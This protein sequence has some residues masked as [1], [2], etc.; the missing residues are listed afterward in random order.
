MQTRPRG[1]A[2]APAAQPSLGSWR[3]PGLA[4]HSSSSAARSWGTEAIGHIPAEL[5]LRGSEAFRI[6]KQTTSL[7]ILGLFRFSTNGI[8]LAVTHCKSQL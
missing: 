3:G 5:L 8:N 4:Q 2:L 1:G 6:Q 7:Y